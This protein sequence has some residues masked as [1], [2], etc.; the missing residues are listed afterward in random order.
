MNPKISKELKKATEL[1]Q[2]K[3]YAMQSAEEETMKLKANFINSTDPAAKEKLKPLLIAAH[4]KLKAAEAEADYADAMFHKL[5]ADE[6]SEIYD[7]LDHKIQEHL[8][9]MQVKRSI[10]RTIAE[11]KTTSTSGRITLKGL[12]KEIQDKKETAKEESLV[13]LQDEVSKWFSSSKKK[14]KSLVDEDEWDEFYELGFEKFPDIAQDD[15]AQAMNNAMGAEGW[16]VEDSSSEMPTEKELE[17][18]SFGDKS[19]QKGVKMGDY[20][21]KMKS[22]KASPTKLYIEKIEYPEGVKTTNDKILDKVAKLL[23]SPKGTIEIGSGSVRGKKIPFQTDDST[24]FN[25]TGQKDHYVLLCK[26]GE[27]EIPRNKIKN[28]EELYDQIEKAIQTGTITKGVKM[29]GYT[30]K[31]S[32]TDLTLP[33]KESKKQ[34]NPL[35]KEVSDLEKLIWSAGG[36]AEHEWEQF[37]SVYLDGETAKYWNDL[38][39]EELKSAFDD[40]TEVVQKYH[41]KGNT[42]ESKK[43]KLRE[44]V[45]ANIDIIAQESKTLADFIKAVKDEYPKLITEPGVNKW[46]GQLYIESKKKKNR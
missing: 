9:R 40:A 5:L 17:T 15:V 23:H 10:K 13:S 3:M 39:D 4:K 44:G 27:F 7:L 22:P 19:Q 33:L 31:N 46:L 18:L 8:V 1:L 36:Q 21:K 45:F 29:E 6:P 20:D 28:A 34:M 35:A 30:K 32:P 24:Y 11:M 14:L 26:N 43:K 12:V 16:L 42:N 2:S 38:S 25:V 37:S 41:L